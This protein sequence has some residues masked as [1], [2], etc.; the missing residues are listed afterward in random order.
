MLKVY[1][2]RIMYFFKSTKNRKRFKDD[3]SDLKQCLLIAGSARS[4][5][6]ILAEAINCEQTRRFIFEP[7]IQEYVPEWPYS[8]ERVYINQKD[9]AEQ[10]RNFYTKLFTGNLRND[11]I[12]HKN[13]VTIAN[14]RIIKAVR[15]N[16]M[17]PWIKRAFPEV[18]ILFI[19]RNPIDVISSRMAMGWEDHL[20]VVMQ[21][22]DLIEKHYSALDWERLPHM[23]AIEKQ[24]IFW[25]LEN[26]W[27]IK[28]LK[29]QDNLVISYK[30]LTRQPSEVLEK[31]N[32]NLGFTIPLKEFK[33][34]LKN[35]SQSSR[36]KRA[37]SVLS[38][39][40]RQ[41]IEHVFKAL[42]AEHYLA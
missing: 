33:K 7:F 4:G 31:I 22:K 18:K 14:G 41:K 38:T 17:I 9:T 10:A 32:L 35:P 28:Y 25:Y 8:S 29:Q 20:D 19:W 23:S 16:L 6:T 34:Q 11:W 1:L 12:D 3:N 5:T 37:K 39:L 15:S 42:D 21:Y 13:T 2:S 36:T 40:D 26:D 30:E 24:A 27:P